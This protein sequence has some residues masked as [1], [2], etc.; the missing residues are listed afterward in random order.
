[1]TKSRIANVV[2]CI[3]VAVSL[4]YWLFLCLGSANGHF[5]REHFMVGLN[6]LFHLWQPI[7]ICVLSLSIVAAVIG[8]RRWALSVLLPI[9]SFLISGMILGSIP[10]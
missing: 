4:A 6:L 3:S 8:S 1:M 10:F 7:W 9:L 5:T 2:G